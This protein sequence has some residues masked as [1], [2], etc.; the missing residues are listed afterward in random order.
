M[1]YSLGPVVDPCRLWRK[2]AQGVELP[3]LH[4]R[5]LLWHPLTREELG[6]RLRVV[7]DGQFH[8]GWLPHWHVTFLSTCEER[9]ERPLGP[10]LFPPRPATSLKIESF[11]PRCGTNLSASST[12]RRYGT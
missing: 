2:A 12:M 10:S 5:E 7:L 1:P 9:L 11:S 6:N 8:Y 3:M 4:G